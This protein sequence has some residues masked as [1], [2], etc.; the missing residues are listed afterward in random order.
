[1]TS[2]GSYAHHLIITLIECHSWDFWTWVPIKTYWVITLRLHAH[3][4]RKCTMRHVWHAHKILSYII[5]DPCTRFYTIYPRNSIIEQ[6]FILATSLRIKEKRKHVPR[7]WLLLLLSMLS[8]SRSKD[9]WKICIFSYFRLINCLYH[10][11]R[12]SASSFSSH[13]PNSVTHIIKE[14]YTSSSYSF[15]FRHTS[16]ASWRGNLKEAISS[17]SIII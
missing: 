6:W 17:Q 9:L 10:L 4:N 11:F 16:M 13:F 2:T 12:S 14:V 5:K 1:M 7:V 15:H 8:I 3:S